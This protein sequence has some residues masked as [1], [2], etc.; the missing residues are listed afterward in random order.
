MVK[1]ISVIIPNYNHS[2]YLQQ[3]VASV[4]DQSYQNFELIIL[5]D[6]STDNSKEII[7][8][9]RNHP[10]VKHI[11]FNSVNSGGTFFQW[12]EGIKLAAGDYIW[13]AESDDYSDPDF[14]SV[15]I[16]LLNKHPDAG[17][18]FCGSNTTNND[19]VINGELVY[20]VMPNANNYYIDAGY[21][22]CKNA[23]FFHPIIPNASAVVFKKE[24][25]FK[26]DPSFK[27]YKI[28]G[29]WQF[30][31]DICFNNYLIYVP[32]KLNYFRQSDT[33][34][35]RSNHHQQN[36]YR[37]FLIEKVKVSLYAYNKVNRQISQKKKVKYLI[38]YLFSVFLE[39]SRKRIRMS[40]N[41]LRFI[42]KSCF[43]ISP[44]TILVILKSGFDVILF[45]SKKIFRPIKTAFVSH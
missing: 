29:D 6:C 3:R 33:S 44:I 41:D 20:N 37:T 31:I 1:L 26:V 19:G 25:Y 34:V 17:L 11:V 16:N 8:S 18:A 5:D 14:L 28:C 21:N 12:E 4:L 43:A 32:K 45:G 2:D 22:E 36:N 27:N 42:I 13:I 23:F 30:W 10:K 38:D 24:N 9:Y 39:I 15:L 35:S 40:K 7:E